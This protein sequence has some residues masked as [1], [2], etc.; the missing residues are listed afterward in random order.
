MRLIFGED[1][2]A[3]LVTT[4]EFPIYKVIHFSCLYLLCIFNMG[5]NLS[6]FIYKHTTSKEENRSIYSC[7]QVLWCDIETW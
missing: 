6:I 3:K 2:L 7:M 4:N 1:I 5:K